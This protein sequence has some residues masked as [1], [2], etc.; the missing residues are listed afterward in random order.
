MSNETDLKQK[1]SSKSIFLCHHVERKDCF[2][3]FTALRY[4]Y[5]ILCSNLMI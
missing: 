4:S 1:M 2:V 3:V 5:L